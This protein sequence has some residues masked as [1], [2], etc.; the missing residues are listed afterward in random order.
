M[1]SEEITGYPSHPGYGADEC[2]IRYVVNPRWGAAH[3]GGYGCGYTGGHCLPG[4][5]C[6]GMINAAAELEANR[7]A[8]EACLHD[9]L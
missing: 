2:P 1:R 5:H 6:Y 3:G 4:K 8:A 9:Q 7:R